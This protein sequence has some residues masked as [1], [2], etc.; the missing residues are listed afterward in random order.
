MAVSLQITSQNHYKG[1]LTACA[2]A[3]AVGFVGKN[4][5]KYLP[6]GVVVGSQILLR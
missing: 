3:F 6:M 1:N 2:N 4:R 5:H